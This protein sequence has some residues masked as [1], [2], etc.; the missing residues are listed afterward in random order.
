MSTDEWRRQRGAGQYGK[1]YNDQWIFV[2]YS[3][4]KPAPTSLHS[5]AW[6]GKNMGRPNVGFKDCLEKVGILQE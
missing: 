2:A 4:A 6:F 5:P 3:Q 1:D